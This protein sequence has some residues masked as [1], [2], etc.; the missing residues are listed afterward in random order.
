MG[1]YDLAALSPTLLSSHQLLPAL[2]RSYPSSPLLILEPYIPEQIFREWNNVLLLIF[3][4]VTA[5]LQC[6]GFQ[7]TY[8]LLPALSPFYCLL[9]ALPIFKRSYPLLIFWTQY[10]T[11]N[12]LD[13]TFLLDK[14]CGHKPKKII[15]STFLPDSR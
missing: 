1:F 4:G 5:M 11:P 14:K 2:S 13:T 8:Q 3:K 12:F 10:S 6:K 15:R 7:L 9:P